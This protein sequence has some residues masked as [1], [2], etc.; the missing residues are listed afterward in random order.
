VAE[1]ELSRPQRD[2][3][4]TRRTRADLGKIAT[5]DD[6]KRTDGGRFWVTDSMSSAP[7]SAYTGAVVA[8]TSA[9]LQEDA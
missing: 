9:A 8:P 6:T 7:G 2:G 4:D 5:F 3:D 1:V